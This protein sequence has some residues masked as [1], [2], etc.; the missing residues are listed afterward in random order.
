MSSKTDALAAHVGVSAPETPKYLLLNNFLSDFFESRKHEEDSYS[1]EMF[2]RSKKLVC[3]ESDPEAVNDLKRSFEEFFRY[4]TGRELLSGIKSGQDKIYMPISLDMLGSANINLRH[5]LY[6]MVSCGNKSNRSNA[7]Q[8][9]RKLYEYLY[10]DTTGIYNIVSRFC[11]NGEKRDSRVN[12]SS[13]F[14]DL[15]QISFFRVLSRQFNEDINIL[16][17]HHNFISQD[18]YKRL[19]DLAVFLT[20]YVVLFFVNRVRESPVL[21]CKG[22]T[23]NSL[24]EGGLHRACISNYQSFRDDF[25]N[26]LAKFYAD[27]MKGA[28]QNGGEDPDK[29]G[30][31]T[32]IHGGE[33][34]EK[35]EESIA[36]KRIDSVRVSNKQGIICV[37]D[38]K[39]MDFANRFLDAKY[40]NDSKL[41]QK[42]ENV[43]GLEPGKY[44]DLSIADF[45]EYYLQLTGKISGTNQ[46]RIFSVLQSSGK[47]IG[48]VYPPTRSKFK[49]F[50]MSGEL[51]AFLVRLYLAKKDLPYDFLDGFMQFLET[52]YGINLRK[53]KKTDKLLKKYQVRVTQ[54]EFGKN[55]EA[56][57]DTLDSVNCLVRLSDSGYIVTL[58]ETKGEFRLL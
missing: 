56:F 24:N 9:Q 50:A 42:A 26:L 17:T 38:L 19:D 14:E 32:D 30:S 37:N 33:T 40:K 16:L 12:S 11:E 48:F 3:Q 57:L 2:C 1:F 25:S 20:F 13:G 54:Q 34:G 31:E 4:F 53:N 39:L 46:K 7:E 45:V 23:S 35:Q 10:G 21:L 47:E 22:S 58:P 51:T 29:N 52:S 36:Q 8:M 6:H 41:Y 49:Y 28:S 44:V 15:K 55:E 43:F 27:R 18:F 5:L